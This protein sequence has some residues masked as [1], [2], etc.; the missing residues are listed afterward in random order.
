[1]EAISCHRAST[2]LGPR[3]GLPALANQ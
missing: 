3:E 2:S 1:V